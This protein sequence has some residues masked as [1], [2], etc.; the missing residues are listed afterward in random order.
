M[1]GRR[2][3]PLGIYEAGGAAGAS[4]AQGTLAGRG[5]ASGAGVYEQV[6]LG[7]NLS[8]AVNVLSAVGGGAGGLSVADN[9]TFYFLPN[10]IYEGGH[11]SFFLTPANRVMVYRD[12]IPFEFKSSG[13]TFRVALAGTVDATISVGIYSN[14]GNTL[15]CKREAVGALAI[16]NTSGAW[17]G[18]DVT[19]TGGYYMVAAVA[20]STGNLPYIWSVSSTA[21]QWAWINAHTTSIGYA[22]N[23][24]VGTA[25]PATLGAIT[26]VIQNLPLLMLEGTA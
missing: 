19:L 25:L 8:M 21:I 14:D 1:A 5:A 9:D 26:G 6:T 11:A 24:S 15:L 18:G 20:H 13:C 7:A 17:D 2:W 3:N 4:L 12:Y 23:P 10:H 16:A 22:A